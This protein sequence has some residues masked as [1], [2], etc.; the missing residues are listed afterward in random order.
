ME[1]IALVPSQFCI[2]FTNLVI[3]IPSSNTSS[4]EKHAIKRV[5]YTV[6][7]ER[8]G[9]GSRKYARLIIRCVR[10]P[11]AC[12]RDGTSMQG[13]VIEWEWTDDSIKFHLVVHLIPILDINASTS[14][15]VEDIALDS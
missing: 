8:V 3:R 4:D 12:S 9:S 7:R 2:W 10:N 14:D 13:V 1:G 11:I 5:G 15:I 6:S